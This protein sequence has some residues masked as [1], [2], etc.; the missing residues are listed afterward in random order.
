VF[1]KVEH[2]EIIAFS[3]GGVTNSVRLRPAAKYSA[4]FSFD[5]K[6]TRM[7]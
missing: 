1:Q 3:V 7:A 2:K 6:R 4:R 5:F